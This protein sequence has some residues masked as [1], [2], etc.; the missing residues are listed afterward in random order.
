MSERSLD[1]ELL[2]RNL[3]QAARK[4]NPG[5]AD[6]CPMRSAVADPNRS[7]GP[8][9]LQRRL[10]RDFGRLRFSPSSFLHSVNIRA[11]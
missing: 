8:A 11:A 6:R 2:R 7:F 1:R 4:L 9:K 5:L 3:V 10:P